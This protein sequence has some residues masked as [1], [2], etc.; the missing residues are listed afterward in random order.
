MDLSFLDKEGYT[1]ILSA[2]DRN[3]D[4]K[5]KILELLI[6]HGAPINKKGINDWTPLH[7]AAAREDI[8]ALEL[9]VEHGTDV[10]IRTYIDDYA[11]ALEE[12]GILG[13]TK[14]VEFLQNYV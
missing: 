6:S 12:A 8:K 7:M 11:T 4:D 10:N 5:Y 3:T 13:K 14:S 9:L 1:P 2:L